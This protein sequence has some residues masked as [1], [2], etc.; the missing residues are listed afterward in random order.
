MKKIIFPLVTLLFSQIAISQ[1]NEVFSVPYT[2]PVEEVTV[3][4][5]P[6]CASSTYATFASQEI[7]KS[8]SGPVEGFS[9]QL[10]A[11]STATVTEEPF[12]SFVGASLYMSNIQFEAGVPYIVSYKYG[13]SDPSKLMNSMQSRIQDPLNNVYV[14]VALHENITGGSIVNF[15]S[16]IINVPTTGTYNLSFDLSSV[17]KQGFFYLDDITIQETEAMG[18]PLGL[19]EN[20]LSDVLVYPNPTSQKF[21]INDEYQQFDKLDIYSIAGQKIFSEPV[22]TTFHEV[23]MANF[24]SGMYI[25]YLHSGDGIKKIKVYKD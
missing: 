23:D 14:N 1:C 18:G 15:V 10:F 11:Y 16:G 7:F 5:L 13:I 6:E 19:E 12:Q 22:T 4:N 17:E 9:G 21:T 2:V 3:P 8:I 25:L 24:S 20:S